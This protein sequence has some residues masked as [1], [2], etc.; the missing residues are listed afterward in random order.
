MGAITGIVLVTPPRRCVTKL[1]RMIRTGAIGPPVYPPKARL[2]VAVDDG[3]YVIFVL[4]ITPEL[5][6]V[7]IV[8][9][10]EQALT[11]WRRIFL[12]IRCS[13]GFFLRQR[14]QVD[15]IVC[16]SSD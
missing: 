7:G 3:P 8:Q 4:E 2:L 14:L 6:F 11:G 16:R 5:H 12:G 10:S 15:V 9:H 1:Q 13:L